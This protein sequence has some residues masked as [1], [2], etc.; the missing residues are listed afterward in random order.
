MNSAHPYWRLENDK[1]TF[2]L[3]PCPGTKGPNVSQSLKELQAA[4]AQGIITLMLTE[5]MEKHQVSHIKDECETLGLT[6]FHLP[7]EDDCAPQEAFQQ[8][9]HEQ[10]QAIFA[11][12]EQKQVLAIHCKGGT[13]RTGLMACQLL[14]ELGAEFEQTKAE[15]KAQRPK[16]L[17]LAPHLQYLQTLVQS[18]K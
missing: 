6:W 17:S 3:T 16:A 18:L 11:M 2:L 1:A 13:G 8:A 9:W 12:I 5:E 7:I 14:L 10:K 4:G 15:I